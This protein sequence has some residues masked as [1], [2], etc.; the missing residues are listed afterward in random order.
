[1]CFSR[2]PPS[3]GAPAG[4]DP[5]TQWAEVLQAIDRLHFQLRVIVHTRSKLQE[6][7]E[8]M[9][10]NI[11]RRFRKRWSRIRRDRYLRMIRLTHEDEAKVHVLLTLLQGGMPDV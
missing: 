1:M 11:N 10:A 3:R 5:Y 9:Q 7:V 4:E 6:E 2:T 8:L